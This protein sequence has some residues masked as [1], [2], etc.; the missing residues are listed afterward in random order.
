[1]RSRPGIATILLIIASACSG[2]GPTDP[3]PAGSGIELTI[4]PGAILFDAAGTTQQLRAYAID[5]NGD[6]SLVAAT[7]ASS[8]PSIVTVTGDVATA[9]PALG[10]AQIVATSGE[11]TSAPVLVLRAT[12]VPGA[13][14][15]A[16]SQVVSAIEPVDPTAT[17]GPGWQYRVR[18]R[19]VSPSTGQVVLASGG[20]PI[21][22]RVV[23][24]A[25]A[26][27]D[28]DVVLEQLSLDQMF[29]ALTVRER[30]SLAN[31]QLAIPEDLRQA[32]RVS[33][34]PSGGVR[35]TPQR[36]AVTYRA[37]AA[38]P[39]AGAVEQ[40]F[41]LGSFKCKAEVPPLFTFPL[42]L[43]VLGL[44]LN[45]TLAFDVVIENLSVQRAVVEGGIAPRLSA[46]PLLTAALE[47]KAECKDEIAIF[48]LPITGVLS[49][50]VGGQVPAGL[51][52]EIG[53]KASFGQLGFDAFLQTAVDAEF[54]VDCAGGCRVITAIDAE[55][56][57]GYFK[58]VLP[59]FNTDVRFELSAS[60]FLWA[61]LTLG[62]PISE[63]L[64]FKTVELKAGL[65]QKFD[66]ATATVQAADP[67]YA[68]SYSL[69][70]VLEA[71]AASNL[72]PIANLLRINLATLTFAPALPT[73]AQSPAGTFTI[74]PASVV[75]GDETQVGEQATFTIALPAATYLGAYAIEGVEIRWRRTVGE[76][77]VLEP[78]R[79]GCT[80]L[81]AAQDQL[82]FTCQ[83][84]FLEEHAGPQ[85]F[86]AFVKTRIWGVPIPVPLEISPNG[87]ATV[88]I[89]ES[90]PT[91]KVTLEGQPSPGSG[92]RVDF[93]N[94]NPSPSCDKFEP[95]DEVDPLPGLALSVPCS[96]NAVS[97]EGAAMS[98]RSNGTM[99]YAFD[100]QGNALRSFTMTAQASAEARGEG[101]VPGNLSA[102]AGRASSHG[103]SNLGFE[104][105]VLAD[106]AEI[107]LAGQLTSNIA[108]PN[109]NANAIASIRIRRGGTDAYFALA[110]RE[111]PADPIQ[112]NVTIGQTLRLPR[113]QYDLEVEVVAYTN[114][115]VDYPVLEAEAGFSLTLTVGP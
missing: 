31:A 85:T 93:M 109:G 99:T 115:Y 80:D 94:A 26:G 74:T 73:L 36:G 65:E 69:K 11:L 114:T 111:F 92:A 35:L 43:D 55:A 6:S 91:T 33:K 51:G 84:D 49:S 44:E 75:A 23:S 1:M 90:A 29:Q 104:F 5:A 28:A 106:E 14:L 50:V 18:L 105:E 77:V 98:G 102:N 15:V 39:S 82:S 3:P 38:R 79:P 110:G 9:G 47:A 76:T 70:P 64:R 72:T 32:F 42:S 113:G 53:A 68:S 67:A 56:P 8:D 66:L 87:A 107:T 25:T 86:H 41:D 81:V 22:G 57:D 13:L 4:A 19:G 16:D 10:S 30:L 108:T 89:S 34:T 63:A 61:E 7:F 37:S 48:I 40:E 2:D 17:Y 88:V 100:L 83:T 12:P 46:K 60:T 45:H 62:S 24:V 78:G 96:V 59:N 54:G 20:A 21:G 97:N 58:P 103:S 27:A 71:K 112:P 101:E 52:F 95:P